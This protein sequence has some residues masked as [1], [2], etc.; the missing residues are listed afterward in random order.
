MRTKKL[1]SQP[2]RLRPRKVC[3]TGPKNIVFTPTALLAFDAVTLKRILSDSVFAE[4]AHAVWEG[5]I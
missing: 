2:E 3:V 5:D 4:N 1:P